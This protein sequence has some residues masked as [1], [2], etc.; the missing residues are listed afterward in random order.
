MHLVQVKWIIPQY[1]INNALLIDN[2]G[3]WR[4]A[5]GLNQH[6][7]CAGI[8]RVVLTCTK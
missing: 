6:L 8:A 1:G 5:E 7:K 3:K 4:D 2:T